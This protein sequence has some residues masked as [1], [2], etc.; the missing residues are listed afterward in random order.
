MS[1]NSIISWMNSLFFTTSPMSKFLVISQIFL[2]YIY[3]RLSIPQVRVSF[4]Q[5]KKRL[6]NHSN[7]TPLWLMLESR[8]CHHVWKLILNLLLIDFLFVTHLFRWRQSCKFSFCQLNISIQSELYYP[9][10]IS[11]SW[12]LFYATWIYSIFH[13]WVQKI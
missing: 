11:C 9:S 13:L 10:D 1:H 7:I 6:N 8:M 3:V 12:F 4:D 2:S 5:F